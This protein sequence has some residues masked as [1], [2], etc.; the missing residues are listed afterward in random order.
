MT[1]RS[2]QRLAH[3][4]ILEPVGKGG[5]GEVYRARDTKLE[6][7]VALKV[8]PPDVA[9]VSERLRRFEQE[10]R[11]ASALNHPN[12]V[13]VYGVGEHEGRPYI[14]M[15]Y[16]RGRTLREV[17]A[18]G[19][20]AVDQIVRHASQLAEGLARAHQA[21]IVHRDLKPEN[22]VVGEDGY[23]KILDF[24]LAKPLSVDAEGGT[25]ATTLER[26]GTTPGAILGTVAYM[27]PEQARGEA[28][29]FR[30]DQFSFGVV[31]Y[32][33]AVARPAFR[34]NSAADTLSAVLRDDP[35]SIGDARPDL[36]PSLRAVVTRCLSKERGARFPSTARLLEALRSDRVDIQPAP[37][38][39]TIAVLPFTNLSSDPEDAYFADGLTDEIIT[40]LSRIRGLQVASGPSAFRF[41]GTDKSTREIAAELNVRHILVGRVRKSGRQFRMMAQLIDAQTDRALWADKYSG[42]LEDVF[43]AQGRV[44]EA[45]ARSLQ[46]ELAGGV[47]APN[48]KALEAYLKGRHFYR[49]GTGDG[50]TNALD[51]FRRATEDDPDYAPA[52]AGIAQTLVWIAN[53]YQED[54]GREA[55]PRARTAAARAIELDPR[56]VEAHVAMGA[57]AVWLDWDP[58][59][60]KHS[61]R[62]ALRLN[63]NDANALYWYTHALIWLD[64]RFGEA[65]AHIQRAVEL[66]P[67][68]PWIRWQHGL[69]HCFSRNFEAALERAAELVALEPSWAL[70][71][72]YRGACCVFTGRLAEA[73]ACFLRSIELADEALPY[74]AWLGVT[75]AL[76]GREAEARRLL[77]EL[78]QH[79]HRDGN[80]D[81]WKL[82]V[83][84]GLGHTEQVMRLLE[85][86]SEARSASLIFMPT[87]PLVDCVRDD[88]RFAALL[89]RMKLDHLVDYR[90]EPAWRPDPAWREV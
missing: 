68:D 63:P 73:R 79:E 13:T 21:G 55:L 50:L 6:R 82:H 11:A 62:E 59:L 75:E 24:G 42:D 35:P 27:S 7:D 39:R 77:K 84:A 36:P 70:G 47:R 49:Q 8:L 69:V 87:H 53:F 10:A 23:L 26:Q 67:V 81:V 3:Y 18:G 44:S 14:V 74:L 48:A 20:L 65:L 28:A 76:A 15:E 46:V 43:E 33:M 56:L 34:R 25:E 60:A 52:H 90:P 2:G 61:F 30:S 80:I 78:D 57:I 88:P 38:G 12:I 5:M 45:I 71:H 9:A 86:A 37:L 66:S 31:V 22:I 54:A 4:E 32:E 41:K 64:T 19:P 17:I 58:A 40:D 16:V 29:D 83:H 72:T 1:I 89:R 85:S 51:C